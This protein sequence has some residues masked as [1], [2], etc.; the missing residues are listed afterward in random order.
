MNQ[1]QSIKT[2]PVELYTGDEVL[3]GRIS[4]PSSSRL[5]DFLNNRAVEIRNA[6]HDLIEFH[7]ILY[8][9]SGEELQETNALHIRKSAIHIVAVD[10][11]DL[12]R[13]AGADRS[14]R[15]YPV[16]NKTQVRVTLRL[17]NYT[18]LST[19]HCI[20][21][22]TIE[23]LINSDITFLPLTHV[24]ITRDQHEYGTRP[25]VAVNKEQIIWLQ[26]DPYG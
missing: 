23:D 10:D 15:V 19:I 2:L 4:C 12:G 1:V 17:P 5:L 6:K 18:L 26:E 25:F 14:Q 22:Q 13:G 8:G 7:S 16:V 3:S 21:E 20:E 24:T 9:T 11:V